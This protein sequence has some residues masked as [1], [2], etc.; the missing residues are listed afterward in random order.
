MIIVTRH[1]VSSLLSSHSLHKWTQKRCYH[2]SK[3]TYVR[4]IIK[5]PNN[6]AIVRSEKDNQSPKI[7]QV[8]AMS[9]EGRW[10]IRYFVRKWKIN[11]I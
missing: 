5:L 4:V 2:Y 1:I 10:Q 11:Y 6:K 9:E 8:S 3:Q 7:W